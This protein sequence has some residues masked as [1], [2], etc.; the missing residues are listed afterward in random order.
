MSAK[1][2]KMARKASADVLTKGG[3][4]PVV[5][6][7]IAIENVQVCL[8]LCQRILIAHIR[9]RYINGKKTAMFH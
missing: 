7:A 5:R 3:R 1:W 9:M 8:N 6:T 2:K 4:N